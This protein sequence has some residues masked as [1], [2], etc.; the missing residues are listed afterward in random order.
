MRRW[1]SWV[2]VEATG[3]ETSSSARS[4]PASSIHGYAQITHTMHRKP[5]PD[6]HAPPYTAPPIHE[7]HTS[8]HAD[9]AWGVHTDL[10]QVISAWPTLSESVRE[11]ILR[12]IQGE[13]VRR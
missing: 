2:G 7:Q 12:L 10:E 4:H 13:E 6:P 11:H 5:V 3:I 1:V 8:V 9:R